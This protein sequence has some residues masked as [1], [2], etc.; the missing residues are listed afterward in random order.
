MRA[1]SL[2]DC[3]IFN[4]SK[5]VQ[6]DI[7]GCFLSVE[8][9]LKNGLQVIFSGTPC[10]INALKAFLGKKNCPADNLLTIDI[11]CHG[12]PGARLW[13]DYRFWLEEK[14]NSRL[15]EFSFRYKGDGSKKR[16]QYSMYARFE[17]GK[18]LEDSFFLRLYMSL[19]FTGLVYRDSCYNCKFSSAKRCSDITIGDFWSYEEVMGK[20]TDTDYGMSLVLVNT[21]KG[22]C[23][24][25]KIAEDNVYMEEC[26][27]DTL[28]R[29][30]SVFGATDKKTD[31]VDAFRE[32]Y[33]NHNIEYVL[34]KYAGYNLKG[35][36]RHIVKKTLTILGLMP[37]VISL[38]RK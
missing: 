17:N 2:I 16:M 8:N 32:D 30:Q 18:V 35:R 4:G 1:D 13:I 25:E 38:K 28:L 9:D 3:N 31:E 22:M 15:V 27:M 14:Y 29:V 23:V 12:T 37:V 6:S 33:K 26:D 20:K 36:I 34:K 7:G 10:Q 21:D 24:V 11:L 5:Y 19:Y